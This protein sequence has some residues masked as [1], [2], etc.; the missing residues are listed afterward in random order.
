[1]KLAVNS[2]P[3]AVYAETKTSK[4]SGKE[5]LAVSVKHSFKDMNGQKAST[6]FNLIDPRDLLVLGNLCQKAYLNIEETR[7]M[8]KF[9]DKP[10]GDEKKEAVVEDDGFNDEIPFD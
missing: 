5:F 1:M 3:F 7:T 2:Y 4:K 6:F 10:K 9:G 8:E